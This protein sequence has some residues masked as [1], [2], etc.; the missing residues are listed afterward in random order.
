MS[1]SPKSLSPQ[2]LSRLPGFDPR[3]VP[4][5][6]ETSVPPAIDAAKLTPQALRT[7]LAAPPRWS[8]EHMADKPDIGPNRRTP[9][10]VLIPVVMRSQAPTVL[11]TERTSH[12]HDHA[13]QIAF[14]GGRR[15][16]TDEDAYH[17]ALREAHEEVGLEARFVEIIGTLPQYVTV[18]GY[19]V[20]PVIGLVDPGFALRLDPFE[21][22]EA[23][24]VPLAWLMDPAQHRRHRAEV[25]GKPRTFWSMPWRPQDVASES[26]AR[27]YFIWGATAAMLRN[28]YRLLSA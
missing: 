5:V 1:T 14:P 8:P 12:L 4:V 13:G 6:A 10:S 24:E 25:D 20:T 11:L 7:R 9:A 18:T 26:G 27:E 15:D 21:V 22:A 16:D 3:K 19:E 28:F 2:S 23:F 17:T